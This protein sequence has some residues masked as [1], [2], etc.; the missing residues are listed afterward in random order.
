MSV[1]IED[2][3]TPEELQ[4]IRAVEAEAAA[5]KLELLR[6]RVANERRRLSTPPRVSRPHRPAWAILV[7]GFILSMGVL[8]IFVMY[9]VAY[10]ASILFRFR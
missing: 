4:K 6:L 3:I 2:I 8:A 9:I 5:L 10:F 1:N 7:P